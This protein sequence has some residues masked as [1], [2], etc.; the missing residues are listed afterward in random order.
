MR[1]LVIYAICVPVAIV[2]GY[3]VVS[4]ASAPTRSALSMMGIVALALTAPIFLRWHHPLLVFCWNLPVVIFF[5]QGDPP[6]AFVMIG[7]SLGISLLQRAMNRNMRF[8]HAPQI[9]LPLCIL[10]GVVLIT[11]EC[12]GGIGL[13]S[14]GSE[15]M[16]G[17]K[18]VF[19]IAGLL[20]Y[21]ALTAR[22]LPPEKARLYVVLFFL[23][24][25]IGVIGDLV[26]ILPGWV[27]FIF[28][29]IPPNGYVMA[30][31]NRF[32]GVA[33]AANAVFL[34]MLFRY[35]IRGIF[36]GGKP[37]RP[38]VLVLAFLGI[39]AGGFRSAVALAV[40]IFAIQFFIEKLHKTKLL[41]IMLFF[42][43]FAATVCVP[44]ANKLPYQAQRALAFLPLKIDPMV[45]ANAEGSRDW[46]IDMWK[47]LLP[48]VPKYLWLGKG[49][50]ITQEDYEFMG[51]DSGFRAIDPSQQ[52]L[53]LAQD[54]HSGPLS[55][56]LPLGIWGCIAVIW[57]FIAGSWALYRNYRYGDERLKTINIALFS[58][59]IAQ[60]ISFLFIF[61]DLASQTITFAGYLGLSVSLNGGICRKTVP[62]PVAVSQTRGPFPL[63]P[64][65]FQPVLSR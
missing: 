16:G 33:A 3:W 49:Y 28:Y 44:F 6:V 29:V 11:V 54:Y 59:F 22:R 52:G 41:P 36:S 18:V 20:G 48:E 12:T 5:L 37:W 50:V 19:L 42:G 14:F 15:T 60:I 55:V 58:L 1:N 25:C 8:I 9:T 62:A 30:G 10:I 31:N 46:R 43:V 47:A 64:P 4:A 39:F 23:P 21:F 24:T 17:K 63:R 57:L 61:G 65:R 51:R 13:H 40:M 2:V 34:F 38:I 7:I 45:R 56:I 53:A 32:G 27:S 26:N 35:G